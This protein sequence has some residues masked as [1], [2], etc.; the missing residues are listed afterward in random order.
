MKL[1]WRMIFTE[2]KEL[3][4]ELCNRGISYQPYSPMVIQVSIPGMGKLLYDH[5]EED[6]TWLE[7]WV[8]ERVVRLQEKEQRNDIYES[9]CYEVSRYM[10]TNK[11][12]QQQFA[13]M[14]DISRRSLNKYLNHE[15]IPKV[16][17]MRRICE[18][19][20]IDI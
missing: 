8:D 16:S 13:D 19:V 10:K 17:T 4:P 3:Y 7:H 6:I 11:L 1:T 2:F 5:S 18:A 20:N 15:A 14:T 12:T 9:F